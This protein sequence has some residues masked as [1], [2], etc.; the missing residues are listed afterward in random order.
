[1]VNLTYAPACNGASLPRFSDK[2]ILPADILEQLVSAR[3]LDLP[4]PLLFEARSGQARCFVGVKEF[5]SD[6]GEVQLPSLIAD[7]LGLASGDTVAIEVCDDVPR[8]TKLSLRLTEIY[9]EIIN[10]KW[11]LEANLSSYTTLTK[12]D[13]LYIEKPHKVYELIVAETEP[14]NSICLIDTDLDL[15]IQPLNDEMA[16]EMARTSSEQNNQDP[17][18]ELQLGRSYTVKTNSTFH[19]LD[20]DSFTPSITA[21]LLV[22]DSADP[23]GFDLLV[24]TNKYVAKDSFIWSSIAG[25]KGSA[26]YV[27]IDRASPLFGKTLFVLPVSWTG[28]SSSFELRIGSSEQIM[29][30]KS[31]NEIIL[32]DQNIECSNCGATVA[33]NS[34]FLHQNFCF[35]NNIRCPKGCG[36]V[37]LKHVPESHWHC[38][39]CNSYGDTPESFDIHQSLNHTE[40][41]CEDCEEKPSFVNRIAYALH[42]ATVCE[43]LLH[44][45]QFCHLE[46]PRG[47]STAE[48][49]LLSFSG[50]EFDCGSRTTE[51]PKC[52]RI[53][54]LRE[55]KSHL[56]LHD[57]ERSHLPV[58]TVC[59]NVN[60]VRVSN[61]TNSPGLC[62]VCFGPSYAAVHDPDGKKLRSRL[63]RRYVI[64]LTKGCG[65]SWC[66]NPECKSSGLQ[67]YGS[68]KEVIEHVTRILSR[69]QEHLAFCVDESTTKKKL[70]VDFVMED[71]GLKFAYEWV[72]KGVNEVDLNDSN[73]SGRIAKLYSW[74]EDNAPELA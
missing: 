13:I 10:W 14:A 34:L 63:E 47:K 26:N 31:D 57:L 74:L 72:C 59:S 52:D 40:M 8:G 4:H 38:E 22:G 58:P 11:F 39:D 2:V 48:A 70:L 50:H 56:Q 37:F 60:C 5:S 6:E 51:C 43:G 15:D 44:E 16:R 32:S 36:K 64:Q 9:P 21:S 69:S 30:T 28:I 12:G 54:K 35:R 66:K 17:P 29:P 65:N 67:Q 7:K 27:T 25:P 49:R 42:R 41:S 20:A 24:S 18:L 68:M 1:M 19:V 33:K 55:L 53:T 61:G 23:S 3:G 46:L 73:E 71:P 45:C 62:D